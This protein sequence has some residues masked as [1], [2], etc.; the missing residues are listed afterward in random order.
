M[1][2][3]LKLSLNLLAAGF[4]LTY[5][6]ASAQAAC[7]SSDCSALGYNKSES[8]CSG[9]IIRCPFDTS[10]VFCKENKIQVGSILYSDKTVSL[11]KIS[12]KTP[13]GIV[14]DGK[15]R[16]AIALTEFRKIAWADS[17]KSN[18][19]IP[20]LPNYSNYSDVSD[21]NGK[22]NTQIIINQCGSACPAA[23]KAYNYTTAGTSVGQWYLPSAGEMD[24]IYKLN[25]TLNDALRKVSGTKV[26]SPDGGYYIS[27]WTS[28]EQSAGSVKA[29]D[30]YTGAMNSYEFKIRTGS[31]IGGHDMTVRPVIAF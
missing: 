28:T 14:F 4:S 2:F 22:S 13:I 6:A 24:V 9:D 19:D 21:Y 27:Y 20:D 25:G 29:T 18:Y 26:F 30:T 15:N 5:L 11:E 23:S 8:A 7:V 31:T 17:S 3:N 12:G 1:T 16:R 10:K